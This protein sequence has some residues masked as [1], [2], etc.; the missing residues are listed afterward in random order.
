MLYSI[1]IPGI[2]KITFEAIRPADQNLGL[3]TAGTMQKQVL[4]SVLLSVLK[5]QFFPM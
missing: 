5:T 4:L 2:L 3:W 1:S